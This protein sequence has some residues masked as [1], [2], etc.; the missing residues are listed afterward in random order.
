MR[1]VDTGVVWGGHDGVLLGVVVVL[2]GV[3]GAA[4]VTAGTGAEGF[5][6]REVRVG[7]GVSTG[8]GWFRY[9]PL[10]VVLEVVFVVGEGNRGEGES[11]SLGEPMRGS[12]DSCEDFVVVVR[13]KQ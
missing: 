10:G 3:S 13:C 2:R 7:A 1:V 5:S 11:E 12:R 6:S 4:V 8:C 9:F